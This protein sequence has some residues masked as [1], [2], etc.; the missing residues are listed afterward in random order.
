MGPRVVVFSCQWSPHYGFQSLYRRGRRGEGEAL[1]VLTTCVGRVGE[2]LVLEAFRR[3]A[4]SV[5][6]L[7]CPAA[8]CR[9]GLDRA[10]L[11]SRIAATRGILATLGIDPELLVAREVAAHEGPQVA[12]ELAELA[13]SLGP[14]R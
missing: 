6:V 7:S 9:H 11:A 3:G 10:R 13:A 1:R 2:D 12:D 14:P 8:E 5:W 4:A